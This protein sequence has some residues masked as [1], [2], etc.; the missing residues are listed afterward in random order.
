METHPHRAGLPAGRPSR[1]G[2]L[3]AAAC[4]LA[5]ACHSTPAPL[6][7]NLDASGL[8]LEG[9]DPVSYFPEGGGEPLPGDPE[10]RARHHGATYWFA[11]EANRERF[12]ADP[13]RYAP[14]YGGWCA[15]AMRD[16][17][18]VEVDPE[19][20]LVQDGRLLLFY[21]SF[22]ADTRARWL[23][24]EAANLRAADAAWERLAR[25]APGR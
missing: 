5:A 10:L 23:E 7:D 18:R 16:G 21:T 22:F 24:A 3:V 1:R 4:L 11:S 14:A 19:S 9:R 25:G 2:V 8:A 15:W 17:E 20:F 13:G 12:V 6:A